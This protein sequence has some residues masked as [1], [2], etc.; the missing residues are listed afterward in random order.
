M[1]VGVPKEIKPGENRVAITP[2]GVD[3]LCRKGHKVLIEQGAG[4]GSGISD[5]EFRVAGAE[6]VSN[7]EDV[8]G[9]ADLVLKVK[10]PL[11]EEF[12]YFREGLILFTYLH[13]AAAPDLARALLEKRV[14]AIAYETVQLANGLLPLLQPM[15]EVAGRLSV[16]IG[17]QFLQKTH[18][19]AGVL[20]SGIP[21]VAS[22]KVVIVGGGT[23]GTN[24]AKVAV[25]L[26]AEVVL[27]EV[28][29]DR[30]RFLDDLFGA[31]VRILMSNPWSIGEEV[32]GADLVIGAVL[33]PGAK[34]PTLVT[35]DMVRT[36]RSGSVIVDVAVDQGGSIATIDRVTT[37]DAPV[38]ERF[39]VLHYAVANIPGAVPRTSTW[40]LV[41]ATLPYIQKLLAAPLAEVFRHDPALRKGLNTY[42][43]Y[44]AHEVVAHSLQLPYRSPEELIS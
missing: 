17:A 32:A 27:F 26:G 42:E 28:N 7:V 11:S 8:W 29:P 20:L 36:M 23:V 31:R 41:N 38:Y 6:I 25:G 34:A 24:A 30:L 2:A 35:E 1:I 37:H 5:D 9:R 18:G 10:E 21:G 13:L 39:G 19:G 14:T 15:S 40:G 43:G 12:R 16:Q 3:V 33:I 44:I 22:G 4:V